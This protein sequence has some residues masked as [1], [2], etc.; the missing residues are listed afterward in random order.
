LS[1]DPTVLFSAYQFQKKSTGIGDFPAALMVASFTT[2]VFTILLKLISSCE[3]VS[4]ITL[5]IVIIT[6]VFCFIFLLFSRD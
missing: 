1:S 3:L 6:T 2:F 5:A 4:S